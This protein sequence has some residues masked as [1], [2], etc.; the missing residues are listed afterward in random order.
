M[1]EGRRLAAVISCQRNEALWLCEWVAY[2][3][4]IGFDR[5]FVISNDCTDG[6]DLILDRLE[7]M[8][9][10][11]HLRQS[12]PPGTAP[13]PAG[14]AL[15][16]AHPAMAGVAWALHCDTDEFLNVTCGEGQVGDLL[17]AV[18]EADCI[19]VSW[20][21]FGAQGRR[22]WPGG[23]VLD[24]SPRSESWI[25]RGR[26][27]QK[28]LFR[29]D[30]FGA[31]VCHMPKA[32]VATDVVLKNTAGLPMPNGALFSGRAMRHRQAAAGAFTWQNATLN[33]YA[34]RSEDVFLM[35]NVR[36]DGMAIQ[37]AKYRRGSPFWIFADANQVE[38]RSIQRHL[39][40]LSARLARYRAD[41]EIA[42]LE[43]AAWQGFCALRE[44]VLFRQGQ[45]GWDKT[46]M[47]GE[48]A[49]MPATAPKTTAPRLRLPDTAPATQL[50]LDRLAP[51][52]PTTVVDVGA[53]PI[54]DVP[55]RA[56]LDMGGCEVIGFEPQPSAFAEL[57]KIKSARERY[58]PFAVGDGSAQELK[59]YRSSGM[60]SVFEPYGPAMDLLGRPRMGHVRERV[61]MPT[62][63]LDSVAEIGRFDL[64]KIDI[65]GGEVAVFRGAAAKLAPAVAVIVE[66]RHLQLYEG[67]PMAAGVDLDLRS[68]GFMLHKFLFNKSLPIRSSQ[69]HRLMP[70]ASREQLVDGD[71]VYL[72]DLTRMETIDDE[73][74]VHLAILASGV[75]ASQTV[76]LACLDELARRGAAPAD[77]PERYVDLLPARL[78]RGA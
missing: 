51:A 76:V 63:A 78:R 62:V 31:V 44:E 20:R 39:P 73:G 74:L 47:Q 67:E 19:A 2:H 36:G 8:G 40:A 3:R 35:K 37:H 52:R 68:R 32:P 49:T 43:A 22:L 27:M 55:Y 7:A 42:R 25:R 30:R 53:N 6:S 72:R 24:S 26:T 18:G 13:Q 56:L 69:Q 50:L 41:P 58:F 29:P 12:P 21:M 4:S 48:T 66:L 59:I 60:T 54:T 28:C 1:D 16:L 33:H 10:V 45:F 61:P 46:E 75:F 65:Q 23:G 9:E 71:A 64:L 5:I 77:L 70:R 17:T 15:A 57:Q 38:E 34:I 14:C 11:I